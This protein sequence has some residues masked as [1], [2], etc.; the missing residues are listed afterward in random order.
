MMRRGN[1]KMFYP[2][3][4]SCFTP[5]YSPATSSL[6]TVFSSR[7]SLDVSV[8]RNSDHNIFFFYQVFDFYLIIQ[9]SDLR[10]TGIAKFIFYLKQFFFDKIIA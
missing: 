9:V 10:F 1:K 7:G 5:H 3:F 4:F 6:C 8:M 2:I